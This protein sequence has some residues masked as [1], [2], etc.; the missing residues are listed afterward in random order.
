MRL[1]DILIG[2]FL[3]TMLI[4]T[5]LIVSFVIWDEKHNGK[6]DK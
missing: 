1:L 2:Y 5:T 3:I 6:G 4:S